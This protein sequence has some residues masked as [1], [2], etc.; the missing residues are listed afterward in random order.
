[1]RIAVGCVKVRLHR[2]IRGR[3]SRDGFRILHSSPCLQASHT[4]LHPRCAG[5]NIQAVIS[6]SGQRIRTGRGFEASVHL[7]IQHSKSGTDTFKRLHHRFVAH[8]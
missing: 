4:G 2:R 6:Q 8:V 7:V 1:L 3:N 5:E